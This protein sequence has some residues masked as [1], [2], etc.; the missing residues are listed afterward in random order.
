MDREPE[1]RSPSLPDELVPDELERLR[2]NGRATDAQF[3]Q[4]PLPIARAMGRGLA[5]LHATP[6]PDGLASRT[7][8]EV[9]SAIAIVDMGNPPPQPFSRVSHAAIRET[10]ASPPERPTSVFT[11]GAPIVASVVLHDSVA[12][13]EPAGTDGLD[14]PERDLAI[15]FRSIAET[16]TSEVAATFLE[17]YIEAGGSLPHGPTLDWYGVVAAFR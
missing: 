8:E 9:A 1:Q 2:L 14:P 5:A 3:A 10:L 13:F 7:D 17:G 15:V 11:H 4:N 12:S 16:F 6:A